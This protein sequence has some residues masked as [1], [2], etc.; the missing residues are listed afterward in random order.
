MHSAIYADTLLRSVALSVARNEV[1]ARRPLSEI[2]AS[3]GITAAEYDQISKNPQFK[4]YYTQYCKDLSENGFSF[5]AKSKVLAEDLLPIAYAMARDP[6]TPAPVRAKLIENFVEWGDLKPKASQLAVTN[7]SG[8]G[9]SII[10][11][12]S[13]EKAEIKD[14]TPAIDAEIA[15][16]SPENDEIGVKIPVLEP[17]V[18]KNDKNGQETA[19]KSAIM[20]ALDSIFDEPE[21]YAGDDIDE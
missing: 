11:P 15:E 2:I 10:F 13:A 19:Q 20:A 12:D 14:I 3:E 8:F 6:D 9:I 5:G 4:R 1:G 17:L 7:G 16:E 21:D 18:H